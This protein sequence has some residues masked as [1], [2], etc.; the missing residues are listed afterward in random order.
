[1][2]LGNLKLPGWQEMKSNCLSK[3]T[4]GWSNTYTNVSLHRIAA[5]PNAFRHK[6]CFVWKYNEMLDDQIEPC[7][8]GIY[9]KMVKVGDTLKNSLGQ[10]RAE[11]RADAFHSL[12]SASWS[13]SVL[14]ASRCT[15]NPIF[16]HGLSNLI[17]SWHLFMD[18]A[19]QSARVASVHLIIESL[20]WQI[21]LQ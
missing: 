7:G 20:L 6:V 2:W 16:I 4:K 19:A 18:F 15:G 10:R 11:F 1:M 5:G 13:C 14:C 17:H 8:S 9:M 12:R 21:A 3:T